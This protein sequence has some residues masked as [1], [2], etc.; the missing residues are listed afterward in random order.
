MANPFSKGLLLAAGSVLIA[1]SG[2]RHDKQPD[3]CQ[4]EQLKPLTFQFLEYPGTPTP[5]TTYSNQVVTFAGPGAPYTAWEWQVGASTTTRSAQNFSLFFD[6]AAKG[7]I[8][9]RLIARRPPST[10]CFPHDDGVDTLTR[11][12]TLVPF[13]DY[14]APTRDPRAPIYG[15]FQGATT[16]APRDTFTVRIYQGAN[17]FYPKDSTAPPTDYVSNLPKSCS[18]LNFDNYLAWRGIFIKLDF[19]S[20]YQG[21]GYIIG[22]DSIR[23]DYL[24]Q[25][26]TDPVNKVFLGKRI[27]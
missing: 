5:D 11:V 9:V 25:G 10:A 4:G 2:C 26:K 14:K 20:G 13:K 21:T 7:P 24:L 19:C 8:R 6:N 27:R 17:Y 23:I 18:R 16:D 12:L 3:P 15:K 1:A 22:R